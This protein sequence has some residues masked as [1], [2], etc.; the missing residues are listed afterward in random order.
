MILV[1]GL[2]DVVLRLL[3]L[4]DL[5]GRDAALVNG[6]KTRWGVALAVV[7]SGGI[8][9]LAYLLVGRRQDSGPERARHLELA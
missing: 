3:A 9:P 4:R 8:L 6:S 5:V 1:T 7:S 2:I